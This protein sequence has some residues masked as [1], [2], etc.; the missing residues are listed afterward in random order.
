[1]VVYGRWHLPRGVCK[2]RPS[3]ML[4]IPPSVWGW[5]EICLGGGGWKRVQVLTPE[6]YWFVHEL[7]VSSG[8]VHGEASE[9]DG[10]AGGLARGL[11]W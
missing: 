5:Q 10:M 7:P 3:G 6:F 8:G 11:A 9:P 4:A 1:M 2:H